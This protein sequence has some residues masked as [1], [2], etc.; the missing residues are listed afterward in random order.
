[1]ARARHRHRHRHP[2][3]GWRRVRQRQ[4]CVHGHAAGGHALHQGRAQALFDQASGP[5]RRLQEDKIHVRHRGRLPA[6][7]DRRGSH[8]DSRLRALGLQACTG[9][10]YRNEVRDGDGTFRNEVF[11][12]S[13]GF[14]DA[15]SASEALP[16]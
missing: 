4:R 5:A 9:T 13:F 14:R 11:S 7:A 1:D 15:G 6:V 10:T 2:R 3:P 16:L 8:R 12:G